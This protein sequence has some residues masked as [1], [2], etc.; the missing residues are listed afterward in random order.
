MPRCTAVMNSR[1][2]YQPRIVT[3]YIGVGTVRDQHQIDVQ[4]LILSCKGIVG[5]L[6]YDDVM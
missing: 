6:R 5:Q 1:G 2:R 3:T 4:Q